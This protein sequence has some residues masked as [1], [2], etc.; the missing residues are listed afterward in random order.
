MEEKNSRLAFHLL[1]KIMEPREM[2]YGIPATRTT[3]VPQ[4]D[5]SNKRQR[6]RLKKFF[7]RVGRNWEVGCCLCCFFLCCVCKSRLHTI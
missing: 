5:S 7:K 1:K 2:G 3:R 4:R 6:G